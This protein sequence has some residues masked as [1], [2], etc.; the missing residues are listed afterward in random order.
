MH[1]NLYK[2]ISL[3]ILLLGSLAVNAAPVADIANTKHN[4]SATG[5]GTVTATTED[6]ICV[7]CHTP[8]AATVGVSPLWNKELSTADGS[9][10]LYSSDSIDA[11][12]EQP[13]GSSKLCLS[14][15]DGAMMIGKV[16]VLDGASTTIAM[17][18]LAGDST[19]P[20]GDGV[21]SG[22]TR[23]LGV[24]LSND[25]PISFDFTTA[26]DSEIYDPNAVA[27]IDNRTSGVH[28]TI[29]L[30][31]DQV[32]CISCHDP[33]VKD[34]A[35]E[36]IKFLRLN[37]IQKVASPTDGSFNSTNDIICLGC[38]KKAGWAN[39]AHANSDADVANEIYTN[40]AATQR[41]F[42]TGIKV[43]EAACLN[44]HDTHTV[45][46]ARKLLR[47]GTD[48]GATPKAG[49]NAAQEETCYQCHD[50][51]GNSI[52]DSANNDVPDIKSDFALTTA[53][54]IDNT[55]EVHSISDE[56]FTESTTLLGKG[57][58]SNRHVECTDCHN[59][60]RVIKNKLFN[61]D[62][63][64]PDAEGTHT[65]VAGTQHTNIAS[66]VL[67]GTTGV[68]PVYGS[69]AWGAVATSY[70]LKKG[71]PTVGGSTDVASSYV[72]REYQV[73]L[74][75]H[76]DYAWDSAPVSGPSIGINGL[77]QYT[78]QAMEFQAPGGDKGESSAAHRSWHPV[79]DA[80]GRTTA[81]RANMDATNFTEP[82]NTGVGSLTMY[83]TDC[84]G[85]ETT[86]GTVEPV[87]PAPWGPHG[88]GKDFILKGNWDAD[89]STAMGANSTS[90]NAVSLCFRC[91]SYD[92][93]SN[94]NNSAANGGTP[95]NFQSGFSSALVGASGAM[96]CTIN[97]TDDLNNLHLG[98]RQR[99]G[100]DL[101]CSWCHAAVP[102]GW[103]NKALLVDITTDSTC[104]GVEP[105][106][107]APYYQNAMLGGGG[108]VAFQLSGSWNHV[109]CGG[110]N[111]F[112]SWMGA[113][114]NN[115][116]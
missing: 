103:K 116:P 105:C 12:L 49:G 43:W 101:R 64:S 44:C 26:L 42:K 93:Y 76:S 89:G 95:A 55:T 27:H 9:Y 28:P 86:M 102:H 106:N 99:I 7:F 104:G 29:P 5:A 66:G 77:T 3:L 87:S 71:V 81:T 96:G 22:F 58:L 41:D 39:S 57:N 1:N 82:F 51:T 14:C 32:Q 108:A 85:S 45:E 23:D 60:H 113:T 34:D 48:S 112:G 10:T 69:A 80:T 98:H 78:D 38:H 36:D 20:A 84:H 65:H 24:D 53:M 16:N 11:I 67:T 75:C 21:T 18:G 114:C 25:H 19:M 91:H 88:S 37:R 56:D 61:A 4:L 90:T 107:D 92:A 8:H 83:C 52:L 100:K 62:P 70:T 6:Q 109:D 54:P 40:A 31:N 79:I 73:C 50:V 33:H 47:E 68:E 63:S 13:G 111:T 15:H 72:T 30:E 35:G 94:V 2:R 115:P 74:K 97:A 17:S 110:A 46:G 59:P